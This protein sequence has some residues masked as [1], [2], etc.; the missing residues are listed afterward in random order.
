MATM[1]KRIDIRA[2]IERSGKGIVEVAGL[3]FPEHQQPYQAL[4]RVMQG[5]GELSES[6]L[7]KLA[8]IS[9][10]TITE[11]FTIEKN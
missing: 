2:V 10:M 5:E 4:R 3:L 9:G 6:Q 11:L 7:R 1:T 8:Q